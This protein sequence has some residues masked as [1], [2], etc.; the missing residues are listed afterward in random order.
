[1][2][3]TFVRL[4]VRGHTSKFV[5]PTKT[6]HRAEIAK[7]LQE[8]T[9]VFKGRPY[10]R[11]ESALE[12]QLLNFLATL[13]PPKG[14]SSCTSDDIINFLI[15]KDKSGKTVLHSQSCSEVNCRVGRLFV[16]KVEGHF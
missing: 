4:V 15:S 9:D 1:M 3:P 6:V 2:L 13:S 8:F 14:I 10:Q 7:R 12:Q 16:R 5:V 11:Q